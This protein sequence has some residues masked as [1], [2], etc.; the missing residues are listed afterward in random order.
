MAVS[1][2]LVVTRQGAITGQK[3][4]GKTGSLGK[5]KRGKK[6]MKYY[7]TIITYCLKRIGQWKQ[8]CL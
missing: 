6:G 2:G 4:C 8:P 7:K 1:T 3:G 5:K